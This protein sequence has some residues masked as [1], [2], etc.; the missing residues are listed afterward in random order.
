MS[1]EWQNNGAGTPFQI[2]LNIKTLETTAANNLQVMAK[3]QQTLATLFA[4]GGVTPI[5]LESAGTTNATSVTAVPTVLRNLVIYN[6][7]ATIYY[8]KLYDKATAP[9]VGTD[10][11]VM[12]IACAVTPT[13]TMP[14]IPAGIKFTNGLALAL[15]L[16]PANT[17][18]TI[19]AVGIQVNLGYS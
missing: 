8:L 6:T 2:Q 16:L 19:A 5:K 1:G 3:I 15:T 14:N 9:T 10:I 13:P 18:T 12:T 7:T 17:D 4:N 11:P